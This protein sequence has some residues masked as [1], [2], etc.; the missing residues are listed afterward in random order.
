[1]QY[2]FIIQQNYMQK[3]QI[4]YS[5]HDSKLH[6]LNGYSSSLSNTSRLIK[7][8]ERELLF[9]SFKM[10]ILSHLN[11]IKTLKLATLT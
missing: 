8:F 3:M 10:L 2:L 1:M 4:L 5:K 7:F 6:L 11:L 9:F